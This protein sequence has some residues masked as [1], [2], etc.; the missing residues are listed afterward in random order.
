[1]GSTLPT[2]RKRLIKFNIF[3]IAIS[4][5]LQM[6]LKTNKIY[7]KPDIFSG[8]WLVGSLSL[9]SL[10][11]I[12]PV[13]AQIVPDATLPNNSAVTTDGNNF[14]INGGTVRGG[15]LFHSFQDFSVPTGG[16]AIF[17]NSLE[18]QNIFS[19]ITGGNPS[20]IDG[21]IQANGAANL[22][23]L[24]PNGIVFGPN[25]QLNIGGSFLATTANRVNFEDGSFFSTNLS[26]DE[27][28]LTISIPNGLQFNGTPGTIVNQ[29]QAEPA[30][31]T[32]TI[33]TALGVAVSPGQT[34]G[35][36]GGEV[37]LDNGNLAAFEGR[38]E[39]GAVVNG[40]VSLTPNDTGFALGY[41][42]VT[43]FGNI[44][45]SNSSVV[46]AS[47]FVGGGGAI[48]VQAN[49]LVVENSGITSS[50]FGSAPGRDFIVNAREIEL[51]GF[52]QVPVP[53]GF[54]L[55]A[56]GFFS[57]TQGDGNGGNLRITAERLTL[58]DGA[59]ISTTTAA[60]GKG[61]NLDITA[62]EI[63]L[64]GFSPD[65]LPSSL[66]SVVEQ[67]PDSPVLATGNAGDITIRS[68]SVKVTDGA[69]IT[70]STG[71]IGN[72]G[73][74]SISTGRLDVRDR[75][76]I[77]ALT[78][79]SV[80]GGNITIETVDLTITGGSQ[81]S[82]NTLAAGRGGNLTVTASGTIELLGTAAEGF[83]SGLF[84]QSQGRLV[85]ENAGDAG[86]VTVSAQN[87]ILSGGAAI[88]ADTF[89]DG[90]GGNVTI[91]VDDTITITGRST[92]PFAPES[93][94]PGSL[95]TQDEDG[96]LPS[97]VTVQT[98]AP[99]NAGS[100]RIETGRL[101]V[102]DKAKVAV[103][104]GLE[105]GAAGDLEVN[106]T[107]LRLDTGIISAQTASGQGGNITLESLD[108]QMRRQSEIS[109][110][111]GTADLPGDGGNIAIG[112]RT[113]AA[114]ENSDISA[115]AFDGRGGAIDLT[116]QGIFGL[117]LRSR[118]DLENLLNPN[119]TSFDP[120]IDL[121][122]TSDITAISRTNP[123][124]SGEV[125][126][127]TPDID[128][129][130]G[131]QDLEAEI[132]DVASLINQDACRIARR[133]EF[134]V[135]GK[136]GLPASP[137]DNLSPS[138]G[139]ED[140]RFTELESHQ[141]QQPPLSDNA[142]NL[143][144]NQPPVAA[145]TTEN[146]P[147]ATGCLSNKNFTTASDFIALGTEASLPPFPRG[148]GGIAAADAPPTTLEDI[149]ITTRSNT[150]FAY[151]NYVRSR[152]GLK[153]GDVV[154][155][156]QLLE[157]LQ[158]LQFDPRIAKI[159]AELSAGVAPNT[160]F[161]TVVVEPTPVLSAEMSLDNGRSPGVGSFRRQIQLTQR[162]LLGLGDTA[163]INYGNTDGSNT[164]DFAWSLPINS[165][166]GTISTFYST[167][168][169]EIIE[170]P[171]DRV[172]IEAE[173]SSYGLSYRQPIIQSVKPK[174]QH[175]SPNREYIRSE[176]ALGL[177]AT[178]TESQ[179]SLL[180]VDFPLSPG[181]N[182]RGE[183]RVSALRFFQD[184]LWQDG[185]QILAARSEFSLGL[186]AFDATINDSEPDSRFFA[187]RGQGQWVRRLQQNSNTLLVVRGDVQLA[188]NSLLPVE[189][190]S[191]GG[192]QSVRGYRQDALLVDNGAFASVELHYPILQFPQ[193]RGN[194]QL[195]P[196]VDFG[197]GW[198]WESISRRNLEKNALFSTGLGVQ[199]QIGSDFIARLDW[200]I[201]LVD[202]DG[203]NMAR[204]RGVFFRK[205]ESFLRRVS[206]L[207][208]LGILGLGFALG[209]PNIWGWD[210]FTVA[211]EVPPVTQAANPQQL[212]ETA[213]EL[214][215]RQEYAAAVEALQQAADIYSSQN[216]YINQSLALSYLGLAYQKLGQWQEAETAI[217]A[218]LQLL[219]A[220]G[221]RKS[222]YQARAIA[223]N[224]Q[225]QLQLAMGQA[226]NAWNSWQQAGENY[227]RYG[228]NEGLSK[229]LVNQAQAL[230]EMGYYRR[231]C[232]RLIEAIGMDDVTC[233]QL[234][235]KDILA[236]VRSGI[237][238]KTDGEFPAI[239][240]RTLG[241][242]LLAMGE[243]ETAVDVFNASAD[244][245]SSSYQNSLSLLALG[246]GEAALGQKKLYFVK[247]NEAK[248][249]VEEAKP[250]VE[251]AKPNVEEPDYVKEVRFHVENALNYYR[252]AAAVTP[253]QITKLLSNINILSLSANME[254]K[255]PELKAK[256]AV[257]LLPQIKSDLAATPK[258]Q[259][260]VKA[261]IHLAC[262][263]MGC[264]DIARGE[265][266][267]PMVA[268][269]EIDDILSQAVQAADDLGDKKLK[270]YALGTL[271]KG[272]EWRLKEEESGSNADLMQAERMTQEAL[273]LVGG[274]NADEIAY[275]WQW[276]LGR[277]RRKVGDVTGAIGYYQ[278]AF[279]SIESVRRN[280][281]NLQ[282][283]IQF[284]FRDNIEPVYRGLVELLLGNAEVFTG[285]KQNPIETALAVMD[286]LRL[287]E[288]ENF[289]GCSF[290][291][292]VPVDTVLE[293]I[294]NTAAFI[295]PIELSNRLEIVF[296]LPGNP[297]AHKAIPV[298]V[299]EVALTVKA[300]QSH[301]DKP[302]HTGEVNQNAEKLYQ[303]LIQPIEVEL[304][305][306]RASGKVKNLVFV[307]DN[308][309]RN[310]PMSVLY[311]NGEYLFQKYAVAVIPSR[312]LFDPRPRDRRL[313]TLMAG[314]SEGQNVDGQDF[315]PL[316]NV[317][318]ELEAIQ[319]LTQ[320]PKP[321]LNQAFTG[322]K[323]QTEIT[324]SDFPIVHI[325]THGEFNADPDETY[326]VAWGQRLKIKQ[327]E[328]MLR[329]N[330]TDRSR[331]LDMLIL[332]ACKTAQGNARSALGLAGVAAQARVRT[333]I[334][335]LWQVNDKTTADL[336][337]KFYQELGEGTEIAEALRRSQMYIFQQKKETRPH[338]WAPFVVV[339]NWL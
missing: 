161:L 93:L 196:F 267:N 321:F 253:D 170:A 150:L 101:N 219:P 127:N 83:P 130:R 185:R 296:K 329:N 241:N 24:N 25:A 133:S 97:R 303:W 200:G 68:N 65:F 84:G 268:M 43:E 76:A 173:S 193:W 252:Q 335:T 242:V 295:Y 320:S 319:R 186:G 39:L 2:L 18:I 116:A 215:R 16:T 339:G 338:Y 166:N 131:L 99:G 6:I 310:I 317:Q 90:Q 147:L 332:S 162:Q 197:V 280:L 9:F 29:S 221:G 181:A 261:Q 189:Q 123:N 122:N 291:P 86:D 163:T 281:V 175:N 63:E 88:S 316:P 251:E 95:P 292:A 110:S 153:P 236:G 312:Q 158:K 271:A 115:N 308:W 313:T 254:A 15:N 198:N 180:G 300:L 10:A 96:R 119:L 159:S 278:Q 273:D 230:A 286:S 202:I 58:R 118:S 304:E 183:T 103:D 48:Q 143:D 190:F 32:N 245:A 262:T 142:A 228:D 179:T 223:F 184:A 75:A 229:M 40:S 50:T 45:L 277:L 288:L 61:G 299:S 315:I 237:Q 206:K 284:N 334:A 214:Y 330:N 59:Q 87:L 265:A 337:E 81:I 28:L 134:I 19:R 165:R 98:T 255:A 126:L 263:L 108:M 52:L 187:W 113:I 85:T 33:G 105:G 194:L 92:L 314:V 20:N 114:L 231:A 109:T 117:V 171:F 287:A 129:S 138:N 324:A 227:R 326:I 100:L 276:Q 54:P 31:F 279:N 256:A 57:Q 178:R 23:F 146:Q 132:V 307:L 66:V 182:D 323:I 192:F 154:N 318:T 128:P 250:N 1:M 333:T 233:D 82:V 172:D 246:N 201:P 49:K 283:D 91:K 248:S 272:Y 77:S 249:Y 270:S 7:M 155:Q 234:K 298:E 225:G 72:A 311:N 222:E 282:S 60:P 4:G 258:S 37:T 217:I 35:F 78:T 220:Q 26:P 247:E 124:L 259:V 89:A 325:A 139:W 14:E 209:I 30:D 290:G 205:V 79:T 42:A 168:T 94:R 137:T 151:D 156:A 213:R 327:F 243:I 240:W 41:E 36:V 17:N 212:I 232:S 145:E 5:K 53:P 67:V 285:N 148:G 46:D 120:A 55:P 107:E 199:L 274:E 224:H 70:T 191:I 71:G 208:L 297:L 218:S 136:G 73:D 207:V 111:A 13:S 235:E 204:K 22:F 140:W 144:Q 44:H 239:A 275:Q 141:R 176:F 260:V 38:I 238:Q 169:S 104:A 106:A 216:N 135:T 21:L 203:Q 112:T 289:L 62:G 301:L 11:F 27:P 188:A 302:H 80:P 306:L 211:Q 64:S 47:G 244:V 293:N 269:G 210:G 174:N 74:I 226:E 157:A 305:T 294:D 167:G 266:A 195:I 309:L 149:R 69:E 264:D 34:L 331:N 152:L 164:W 3:W 336:V 160:S 322:G 56:A 121:P 8:G 102:V 51:S 125:A 257:E 328:Q 12:N 177:S